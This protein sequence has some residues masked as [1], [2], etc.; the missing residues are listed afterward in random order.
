MGP[1]CPKVIVDH[2]WEGSKHYHQVLPV[3]L[4][5]SSSGFIGH[6]IGLNMVE[7]PVMA[8]YSQETLSPGMV[9]ALEPCITSRYGWFNM[10]RM[11][12]ITDDGFELLSNAPIDLYEIS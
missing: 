3:D 9:L 5:I 8:T 11:I 2:F 4:A 12:L 7:A 10:E 6:G 1:I